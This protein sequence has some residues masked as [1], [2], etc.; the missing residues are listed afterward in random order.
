MQPDDVLHLQD[1][2]IQIRI[3]EIFQEYKA[4]IV[5]KSGDLRSRVGIS[6]PFKYL[7]LQ[8]IP[9]AQLSQIEW[10]AHGRISHLAMSYVQSENDIQKLREAC[11]TYNYQPL[12]IAKIEH[13]LALENLE[14]I[15]CEADEVW[16]CRGDLGT[17]IPLNKLA[18][19]QQK[20]IEI[21]QKNDCPIF[22]AG[23][24]F[25]HLTHFTEATRSEIV[26]FS[27]LIHQNVD[28][29][30][31]SDETAIGDNPENAIRQIAQLL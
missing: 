17:F 15:S 30:I 23:Q 3:T 13:P 12:I 9:A 20:T 26:H 8:K 1:G 22:I 16:F 2:E 6:N 14:N 4:A 11:G 24:V 10:A 19:W 25:H 5:I 27:Q 29:I 31:L 28:G 7:P 18:Q 21:C